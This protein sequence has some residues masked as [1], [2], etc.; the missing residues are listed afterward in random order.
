MGVRGQLES[1]VHENAWQH[2]RAVADAYF[3]SGDLERAQETYLKLL[4]D[5]EEAPW[6]HYQLGRIDSLRRNW[7]Q[8]V[9]WFDAA[10]AHENPCV[11]SHFEKAEVLVRQNADAKT[12]A[13]ELIAFVRQAPADL[14]E[15]HYDAVQRHANAIFNAG[16]Y[17]E[18]GPLYDWLAERGKGGLICQMRCA[19]L[20]LQN[21]DPK[22]AFAIARTLAADDRYNIRAHILK[23]RALLALDR[24]AEAVVTLKSIVARVPGNAEAIRLLFVALQRDPGRKELLKPEKYLTRLPKSQRF[25]FLLQAKLACKDFDGVTNLCKEYSTAEVS[26]HAEMIA[27]AM[28]PFIQNRDFAS[29]DALFEMAGGAGSNSPHLISAQI[30]SHLHRKDLDAAGALVRL[31]EPLLAATGDVELRHMKLHYLCLSME[32]DEASRYL[33][34]WAGEGEL[35]ESVTGIVTALYSARGEWNEVLDFAHDRFGHN[36]NIGNDVLLDAVAQAARSTGRYQDV[37][38][39]FDR[40]IEQAPHPVL[41]DFRDRLLCE[42]I[43]IADIGDQQFAE[44]ADGT[45]AIANPY[46]AQR[47][48]ALTRSLSKSHRDSVEGNVYFCSDLNYF[49]GTAVA[50]FSLLQN[51]FSIRKNCTVSVF[52]DD[53]MLEF[54][55]EICGRIGE[56]FSVP[57]HMVAAQA[58]L[59]A[60]GNFKSTW[61]LFSTSH[62]LSD[63]AYYRIF[64]AQKLLADGVRGR[65]LYIDSD[66]CIGSGVEQILG[67]DLEGQPLGARV[68]ADLPEIG[69]AAL[70]LGVEPEKYFN[71]GVLLFDLDH[72]DLSSALDRAVWT[73]IQ[74]KDLLTFVDQC[75]LNLAFRDRYSPFPEDFNWYLRQST[76]V[77]AIPPDAVVLHFLARPKPWDPAY[78]AVHCMRWVREFVQLAGLLTPALRRRLLASQFASVSPENV[79]LDRIA[80]Q[81]HCRS[82][83]HVDLFDRLGS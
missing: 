83:H 35:P 51:N 8:A 46:F 20:R 66:T 13:N 67:F 39:L 42:R 26:P 70:K 5:G 9:A 28:R 59:G 3:D 48:R 81:F 38:E 19:F 63:A 54:A 82:E 21:N 14:S 80:K 77:E 49:V 36:M 43:L 24:T 60:A 69:R 18:A 75:A 76:P 7:S 22:S 72:P 52:C 68:E 57:I 53:G 31:S 41:S 65:A 11:W 79:L 4:E 47:T 23:A 64:A 2:D 15:T 29:S 16:F 74:Q 25:E 44:D 71:S 17:A 37:L 10:L 34:Q 32:L 45:D 73:S 56:A 50:L 40:A 33:A 62:G 12:I 55:S 27:Y 78:A 1:T 58:L 6:C 30:M 61:G